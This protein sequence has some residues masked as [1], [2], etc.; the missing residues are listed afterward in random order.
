MLITMHIFFLPLVTTNMYIYFRST[1][2][3]IHKKPNTDFKKVTQAH[4]F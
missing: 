2:E 1:L 3:L 4:K